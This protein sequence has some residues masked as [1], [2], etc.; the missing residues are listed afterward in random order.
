MD[1]QLLESNEPFHHAGTGGCSNGSHVGFVGK[2]FS[3]DQLDD[4]SLNNKAIHQLAHILRQDPFC[5]YILL[6]RLCI[7]RFIHDDKLHFR[8][9][10][11]SSVPTSPTLPLEF[12]LGQNVLQAANY[13][14]PSGILSRPNDLADGSSGDAKRK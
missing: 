4:H 10:L 11:V 5:W 14:P 2:W 8:H 6:H 3:N 12:Q 7:C 9:V 1:A 13:S